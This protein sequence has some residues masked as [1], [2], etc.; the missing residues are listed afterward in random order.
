MFVLNEDN[1]IYATRGDIVF[2]GVSAMDKEAGVPYKF[3]AGDVVRIKIFGKKAAENVVLEKEFPVH[4]VTETVEIFLTKEDTKIGEVI[5]KPV[6]YWYEVELNPFDNPQTIIGYDE[7]GA[8]VFK[9]FPEGADLT[10]YKPTP[11]DIPFVDAELDMSSE[12]PVQNQAIARMFASLKGL[13]EKTHEAVA[14]VNVTPEMYGAIGDGVADDTE[15][16]SEAIANATGTIRL[17]G[18]YLITSPIV[19]KKDNFSI[20][21]GKLI[22]NDRGANEFILEVSGSHILFDGVQFQHIG[23]ENAANKE[24]KNGIKFYSC[25][26]VTLRDC[27]FT[28][29]NA[30]VNGVL[31][32]YNNWSNVTLDNCRFYVNTYYDGAYHGGGVW[33]RD[34]Y[35]EGCKNLN[36]V[37]CT[38]NSESI[39]EV[40]A[41]WSANAGGVKNVNLVNNKFIGS[42]MAHMVTVCCENANI[43]GCS[44]L[45]KVSQTIL[46]C[47]FDA[48]PVSNCLVSD[49]LFVDSLEG[50]S[51]LKMVSNEKGGDSRIDVKNSRFRGKSFGS[52]RCVF[53][54][55][56]IEATENRSNNSNSEFYS[57]KIKNTQAANQFIHVTATLKNCEVETSGQFIQPL[58]ESTFTI[59]GNVIK[60]A[61]SSFLVSGAA[62]TVVMM[63]NDFREKVPDLY[64]LAA[65]DVVMGNRF[66]VSPN[67]NTSNP[68]LG[69][70]SNVVG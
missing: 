7:N 4:E 18:T 66:A 16:L 22:L 49:C 50:N 32:C 12:R 42:G 44:F 47:F 59:Q 30:H 56:D 29:Q 20:V 23:Y 45:S 51:E 57:C 3:Q 38:F 70:D 10:E 54:N 36:I 17:T 27:D 69:W 11:E 31:D 1:S 35:K 62:K 64:T 8:K 21:G 6:D 24:A 68:A 46:K 13:H 61:D 37:N 28:A 41:I 67:P 14:Q 26:F 55:C 25:D 34:F 2:F 63:N 19:V 15:A 33:F 53:H 43:V 48:I 40:V 60:S 65:S 9:L 5:S 39:D 52:N 58:Y